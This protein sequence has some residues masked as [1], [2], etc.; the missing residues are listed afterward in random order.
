MY[1]E[2]VCILGFVVILACVPV[3]HISHLD[4][5]LLLESMICLACLTCRTC[6]RLFHLLYT[7]PESLCFLAVVVILA[8][9]PVVHMLHPDHPLPVES[10]VCFA[11]LA[12][13]CMHFGHLLH[14]IRSEHQRVMQE[15]KDMTYTCRES[16]CLL[17]FVVIFACVPVVLI[18]HLDNTLLHGSMI[19]FA[20]EQ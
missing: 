14:Q 6:M 9:V 4:H 13:V 2:S 8:S 11:C 19:C 1:A 12:C 20:W 15:Q 10:M 3:V 17:A 16:E 18:L 5:P 7:V